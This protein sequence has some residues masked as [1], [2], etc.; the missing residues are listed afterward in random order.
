MELWLIAA[1]ARDGA[2][3]RAGTMPWHLPQDLAHFKRTTLGCPVVMGR[4]TWESLPPRFRPLPGR[5][6]VV[7]TRNAAWQADGA[8]AAPSLDAALKR[9]RE[10]E[11]VFVIGGG[12][13]YAQALPRADGLVL[14]EVD[15]DV[16]DADTHFPFWDR[17]AFTEATRE[18]HAD[19]APWP[20]HF[21]RYERVPR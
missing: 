20:Y 2:I 6:N 12:E 5:R 9:L 21:V 10:A 8:E 19:G 14:T 17:G 4:K 18:S 3:G 15:T 7:V 16:P 13:L 11:R 1:V